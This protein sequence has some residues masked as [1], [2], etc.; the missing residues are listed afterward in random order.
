MAI[1]TPF[2]ELFGVAHPLALAPMGGVSG[3]AL[4]A[5][6]SEAGGLGLVGGGY[7]DPRWL[8]RELK[9]VAGATGR[10]WGGGG[11]HLRRPGTGAGGRRDRRR[12]G[13]EAAL[14]ASAEAREQFT[15]GHQAGDPDVGLVWAGEGADLVTGVEPA[16]NLVTRTMAQAEGLL[17]AAPRQLDH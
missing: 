1:R 9:L 7:G 8:D 6:V 2:T 15:V 13:R 4:A 14:R 12:A 5:A 17:R 10:P 3:G 16:G 11:D